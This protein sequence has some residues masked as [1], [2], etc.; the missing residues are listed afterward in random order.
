MIKL[1]DYQ[2]EGIEAAR[3]ALREGA[4]SVL[5]EAATGA[6]KSF[7]MAG[8]LA[9]ILK[10]SPEFTAC[11][12]VPRVQ[13]IGQLKDSLLA[14]GVTPA[15]YC[16]S[17]KSYNIGPIT[18]A[19]YQSLYTAEGLRTFDMVVQDETHRYNTDH[20][21]RFKELHARLSH[22]DTRTVGFTATPYRNGKP[23]WMQSKSFWREP[24]WRMGIAELTR[25]HMLVP[26]KL[27]GGKHKHDTK[28]LKIE[29]GDWATADLTALGQD[30]SKLRL[31]VE[32]ALTHLDIHNRSKVIWICIDKA[33]AEATRDML[34]SLG[35]QAEFII[36]D[37]SQSERV[38]LLDSFHTGNTRHMVSVGILKEGYDFP[39]VDAVVFLRPTRSVVDYVQAVGR[40]LRPFDGKSYSTILDYGDV[41][42]NCGPL[43]RPLVDMTGE[44]RDSK[45]A[46]D[47]LA[48]QM[49][50]TVVQCSECGVFFFPERQSTKICPDCG[51]D[52]E[53]AKT[54]NL[55]TK[56]ATGELYTSK[57]LVGHEWGRFTVLGMKPPVQ[58]HTGCVLEFDVCSSV[59]GSQSKGT[60]Y[61]KLF[62]QRMA[63]TKHDVFKLRH[64]KQWCVKAFGVS[65][66]MTT[67]EMIDFVCSSRLKQIPRELVLDNTATGY[68]PQ[69]AQPVGE[70]IARDHAMQE[71]L[72]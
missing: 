66:D 71:T 36:S 30:T 6:G 49:G 51:H 15:I 12:L 38:D 5:M 61:V 56:A 29:R 4:R 14:M 47:K 54:K 59:I 21:S 48:E 8:L 34:K 70:S 44:M 1:R 33:H 27:I 42:K 7:V 39:A 20:D 69:G 13:L 43:D 65:P 45:S 62:S 58:T 18:L 55:R 60:V 41:V 25:R 23:M 35:E 19:T 16:G 2:V 31:Q 17:L 53:D 67:Q 24:V 46:R 28:K 9:S 57:D 68:A 37:H 26:A 32:D 40:A 52:C 22:T 10:R 64:T 50:Y 11:I 63:N 72:L 3:H